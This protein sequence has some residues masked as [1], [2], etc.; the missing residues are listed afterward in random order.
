MIILIYIVFFLFSAGQLFY[1]DEVVFVIA[2]KEIASGQITGHFGFGAG[3]I[4]EDRSYMIG[5]PP[6]YT[7]LLALFIFLF[8]ES[9]YSIR[10]VSAIFAI[11]VII[12]IYLITKKILQK[13]NV[14]NHETWA[15]I[16]AFLYAI[17]PIVIQNSILVDIDGG[18][19]N[20]FALLFL[21]LYISKKNLVYLIPSLFMVFWSKITS[22]AILFASLL[23]LNVGGKDY[24]EVWKII[25]LFVIS[26][27]CFFL[28][29][30]AYA[31][32]C[33]LD[34]RVLFIHNSAFGI[35]SFLIKNPYLVIARSLWA[36]KTFFYFA[37]PFLIFLFIILSYKILRNILKNKYD[38]IN[39]NKDIILLWFYA[40][41]I[42][43]FYLITGLTGWNFPKYHV[44]AVPS[45]IILLIYFMPKKIINIKKIIPLAIITILLLSAYFIIF[46]GDPLIPE[47][48]GRVVTSSFYQVAKA[49]LIRTFLYAIIPLFLCIGLF[50]RIP[51]KK[52]W[53]IL[54]FLIIFTSVYVNIIQAKADYSTHNL[55]GDKGLEEVLD[56]MKEVP[57]SEILCYHHVGYYLG[58][59]EIS[60]LATVLYNKPKLME[61]IQTKNINW[62]ILYQKDIIFIGEENLKDFKLEK[63]IGDYY[64]LKR[65]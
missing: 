60:E 50:E 42:I 44:A 51:K 28:S 18:L 8:G 22:P 36:L 23:L 52:I 65:K 27:G 5:H 56:F 2:A 24:K 15:L 32:L 37:V 53:L 19:L 26:G 49:V 38:Y 13:R 62:I 30:F 25:K 59:L 16:A 29:F 3:K 6:T 35:L 34:W 63:Q 48:G 31:K 41:M 39:E 17:S 4:L 40:I 61:I 45:I 7:Y 11:G 55:Y 54:F 43:L 14:K 33:S 64:I 21:Y 57:P 9:T 47:I 10:A 12:L 58:Y 20:F 46:L 1:G